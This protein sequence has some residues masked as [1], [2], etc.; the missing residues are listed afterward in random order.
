[1]GSNQDKDKR[2]NRRNGDLHECGIIRCQVLS[3]CSALCFKWFFLLPCIEN[4][5][6]WGREVYMLLVFTIKMF[7]YGN[8]SKLYV[9]YVNMES[10][11]WKSV[12][13]RRGCKYINL[14]SAIHSAIDSSLK[15]SSWLSQFYFYVLAGILLSYFVPQGF[16]LFSFLPIYS[17][18]SHHWLKMYSGS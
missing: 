7:P 8:L 4:I 17:V 15:T 6:V 10:S 2:N 5:A 16:A 12:C 13:K 11:L 1:M 18:L 3:H 9:Y 14:V